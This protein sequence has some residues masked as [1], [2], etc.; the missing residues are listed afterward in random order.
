MNQLSTL[1]E[2]VSIFM[3]EGFGVSM[4]YENMILVLYPGYSI[5]INVRCTLS[6]SLS[7][8]YLKTGHQKIY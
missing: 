5:L 1:L 2:R 3:L 4:A 7:L 8:V 6:V